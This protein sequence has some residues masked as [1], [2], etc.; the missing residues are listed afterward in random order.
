MAKHSIRFAATLALVGG[1]VAACGG[2]GE[3]RMAP[4]PVREVGAFV[5]R[6][7]DDTVAVEEFS[8][9][10]DRIE[11]RQVVRTP[12]TLIREYSGTLRADGS[13]ER[14]ELTVHPPGSTQPTTRASI[15]FVD[16]TA[17][18]RVV[19]NG[20]EQTQQLDAP[21]G[22]IPWLSYSV[23]LYEL[24]F[25]RLR[26]SDADSLRAALIPLGPAQSFDFA[27]HPHGSDSLLIRNIAGE[28]RARVDA[29]GR[30]LFWDGR[31][32]TIYITGD[33]V[34][35]VD[36]ERLAA[37][38]AARDAAG[39]GLGALSPRD[40]VAMSLGDATLRF[41]YSRPLKRGRD[42][43][44]SVVPWDQVWRTG[45]NQA[46]HFHA[47]ADLLIGQTPVPA[48]TYTLFTIPGREAW[49]LI[50]NRQTGQWGTD[51]DPAQDLARI[52]MNRESVREP[53]EQL[54]I[55][56]VDVENARGVLQIAWDDT[57]A[58]VPIRA[59]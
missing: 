32:S 43:F 17:R 4:V 27:I 12:R 2:P 35:T 45:A 56:V 42:I 26:A 58:W 36:L 25:A 24:P 5:V 31:G 6:L 29:A 7:G 53:V 13:L 14:F 37:D 40:S 48:G 28:N 46:T 22:S 44:G 34:V 50:I 38:F 3:P 11:G 33:R 47:D 59:Q 10:A 15:E 55:S 19:S 57:R 51:Y 9:T 8:R 16:Q 30:L 54:T 23:A 20:N 21:V 52:P 49:Q 39:A 1:M 41:E 18:V